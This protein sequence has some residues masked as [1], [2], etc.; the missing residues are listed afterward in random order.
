MPR[1][2]ALLIARNE[3]FCDRMLAV[4]DTLAKQRRSE[5]IV[6]QVVGAGTSVGANLFEAD[7]A[8]SRAD[9]CKCLGTATKE[10]SECR[11]WLR[12]IS[13]QGW[14]VSKRPEPPEVEAVEIMKI[15]NA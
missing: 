1:I 8:M 7:Q 5:R 4:A 13:R 14:I 12:L 10:A 15:L 6:D 2:D 3:R 11:F 9:F